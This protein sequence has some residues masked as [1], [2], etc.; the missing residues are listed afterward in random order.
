MTAPA[1]HCFEAAGLGR[2]PF[3]CVGVASI[4][5][6]SLA[7]HNPSAYNNAMAMLPRDYCCGT[8]AY[9]GTALMHNFMINSADGRKFV[10]GCDCVRRTGD[11][12]LHKEVRAVR[13]AVV[14]VERASR[15]D[16][17]R[18]ARQAAYQQARD[19]RATI[20]RAEHAA[21][22]TRTAPYMADGGFVK[23]VMDR[24]LTGGYTTERALAAVER[25][26]ADLEL[27]AAALP[28]PT[29]KL[30][31]RGWLARVGHRARQH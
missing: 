25:V 27:R 2:A 30:R 1:V 26:V 9:C 6:A 29:G 18:A 3:H 14:R 31:V 16:M 12:G 17:D 15:R 24:G 8:C 10:V 11:A 4:P 13:L 7:E 21:L 19:D 28:V 20:F 23:D 5:S 22:I